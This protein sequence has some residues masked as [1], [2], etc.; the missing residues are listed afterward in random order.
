MVTTEWLIN[1]GTYRL[2]CNVQCFEGGVTVG[3]LDAGPRIG[4]PSAN[5]MLIGP[6]IGLILPATDQDTFP[7]LSPH[8]M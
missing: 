2:S 5:V 1:R 4:L 6:K 3:L 7:W 8:A